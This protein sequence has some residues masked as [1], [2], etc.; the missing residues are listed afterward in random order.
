MPQLLEKFD[1]KEWEISPVNTGFLIWV[2]ALICSAKNIEC[3]L[4]RKILIGNKQNGRLR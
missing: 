2:I 1:V 3:V 4:P